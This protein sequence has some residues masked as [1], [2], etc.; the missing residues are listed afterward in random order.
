MPL[1]EAA[2]RTRTTREWLDRL[3]TANVPAT[4]ILTVDRVL[5]DP[6]VLQRG[7]VAQMNHP[8]HGTINTLGTPIKI[9]G[10]MGLELTPPPR[11]GEHTNDILSRV[12]K[13]S[14]VKIAELHATGAI[15]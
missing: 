5:A 14:N 3:Q 11:L 13:Y 2:F 7:M 4:P 12:L 15:A 8:R 9:D 10:A 6:Q 1:V